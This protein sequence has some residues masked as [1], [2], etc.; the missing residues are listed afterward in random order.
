MN[1]EAPVLLITFNRPDTTIEVFKKIKEAKVKKLYFF[2]DAPRKNNFEDKEAREKIRKIVEMV[3][4]D[5][6]L[7]TWFSEKNLGCGPGP[8]SAISWALNKEDRIIIL[9]D[10]CV[11][12]MP[13]FDYCNELL[14]KY[15]DDTRIWL[16]SGNNY[17]E[18]KKVADY[19]YFFSK[20]GH[21][22]G[23]ATWKRCWEHFDLEMKKFPQ[24]YKQKR[25]YDAY[26]TKQE[27]EFFTKKQKSIFDDK[28]KLSHIWDFQAGFMIRSNGGICINPRKNLVK[29]IGYMG[30]HSEVKNKFHDRMIDESYKLVKHPDFVLVSKQYD[31][32][33]FK[34]H[35]MKM[36]TPLHKRIINKLCKTIYND[37]KR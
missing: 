32:Y 5:C 19:D 31:D 16:I 34:N 21:S 27:A 13:F 7:H 14:E 15:K 25:Y 8:S 30:T 35:W 3:D 22:W 26:N 28:T 4:W 2:N 11:P 17:T 12:A 9:E 29:N 37:K 23:W 36:K 24:Y 20:Y 18:E 6:E 33:H 10:D 1:P